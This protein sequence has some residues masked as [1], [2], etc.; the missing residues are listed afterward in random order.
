MTSMTSDP[1]LNTGAL[2]LDAMTDDEATEA[3]AHVADCESCAAELAGFLETAALLGSVAAEVP[4]SSLRRAV[5][6]AIAITPQLP[7]VVGQ[8]ERPGLPGPRHALPADTQP[9]DTQPADTQPADAQPG[10]AQPDNPDDPAG[11][12]APIAPTGP[13]GATVPTSGTVVP[14][15]RPWYRRP[16]AFIAAAVAA[17]VIGGG[18]VVAVNRTSS[19]PD[20]QVALEQCVQHAG[21]AQVLT[22]A[23][24]QGEVRYAPS[25]NAALVDVSG[26]RDL[27]A[28]RTYQLWVLAG[29]NARS[30]TLLTQ[31][32]DGQPQVWAAPTRA[33]DTAIGITEEPA[34]GSPQPT[35]DP[36]W[37]VTLPA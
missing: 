27:P 31:A 30:V 24:A 35:S 14:L 22:P 11:P 9:A 16:A 37:G 1:H 28:D 4:P 21:D 33:G 19:P 13:T 15:R 25:C 2:A 26:L 6:A 5:M 20:Q 32:A 34:T 36:I 8:H 18:V 7:P 12:A 10:D 3:V 23:D 17:V 29:S